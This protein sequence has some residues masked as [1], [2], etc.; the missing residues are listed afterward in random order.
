MRPLFLFCPLGLTGQ[1]GALLLLG[2]GDGKL[3]FWKLT[4][5]CKKSILWKDKNRKLNLR[6]GGNSHSSMMWIF[7]EGVNKWNGDLFGE[8]WGVTIWGLL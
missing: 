3:Y 4:V 8:D 6:N 7:I 1:C 2:G 5:S